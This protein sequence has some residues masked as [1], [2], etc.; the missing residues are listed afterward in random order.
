MY[1]EVLYT[2]AVLTQ[3]IGECIEWYST[4]YVQQRL[5]GNNDSRA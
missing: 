4:E 5:K 3:A 1:G 2:V